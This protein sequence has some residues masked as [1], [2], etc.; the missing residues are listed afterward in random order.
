[1]ST[2]K[3][4]EPILKEIEEYRKSGDIKVVPAIL[5]ILRNNEDDQISKAATLLLSDIKDDK[6]IDMLIDALHQPDNNNI[7]KQLIQVCWESGL[8]Y[9]DHLEYFVDLFLVLDY[10]GALEAFS[11]I[12]NTLMDRDITENTK[13]NLVT[14]IRAVILDLP[15]HNRNLGLE[16][17]HLLEGR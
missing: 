9:T 14:K 13:K 3:S 1:M 4:K 6:M 8:D 2:N 11:L 17:I 5:N 12:E 7:R 16:L 10:M 15:E